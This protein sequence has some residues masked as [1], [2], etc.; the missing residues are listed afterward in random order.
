MA[1]ELWVPLRGILRSLDLHVGA[2]AV[3][4]GRDQHLALA[5]FHWFPAPVRYA[6]MGFIVL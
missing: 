6:R 3:S 2:A 5:G 1:T 4:Y